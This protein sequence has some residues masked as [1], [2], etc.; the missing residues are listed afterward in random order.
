MVKVLIAD[1]S[2]VVRSMVSQVLSEDPR[3]QLVGAA[4]TGLKA[5]SLNKETWTSPCHKWTALRQPGKY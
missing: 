1:D 2:A 5:V 4:E 3:F